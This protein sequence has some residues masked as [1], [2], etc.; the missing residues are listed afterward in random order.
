LCHVVTH[1]FFKALLFLGSGSVIHAMSGEQDIRKMGGLKDKLPVTRATFLIGTLAI[2]GLPPFAGF[3]SKDEILAAVY[4][5][6]PTLFAL[7][8]VASLLTAVYMFR[9]YWL[10]FHGTFRGTAQQQAHLHESPLTMTLPLMVLAVLSAAGGF[11][12]MPAIFHAPHLLNDYLAPI[13]GHGAGHEV[14]HTFE[15]V[16]IGVSVPVLL[17]VVYLTYRFYVGRA[18]VPEPDDKQEGGFQAL[19]YHKYYIDELYEAVITRPLNS[20]SAAAYKYVE[21]GIIDR[22]INNTGKTLKS[23]SNMLRLV[24]TGDTGAYIFGM[25]IGVIVLLA[26][27]LFR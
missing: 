3:F 20:L 18:N 22:I 19:V 24:Q 9:L 1:A 6:S 4:G 5:Y 2:A 15:Y 17:T 10:V 8:C 14:S 25:V 7:L 16:L 11:I 21:N 13:L 12:G 23:A 26:Y 27:T